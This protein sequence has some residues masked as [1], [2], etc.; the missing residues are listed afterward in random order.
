MTLTGLP[1]LYHHFPN[2]SAQQ[3]DRFA[4]LQGLYAEW[5]EKINVISRKDIENL[6][7][8]HVLHSLAI[9]KVV[10]FNP[11]AE[12]LDVGTGG[13][14]PGIPLAIL[15]PDTLFY[16][17]DSIGK[18]IVVVQAVKDA[19]GLDNVFAENIRSERFDGHV[20]FAVTRAVAP[21]ADL[22]QWT[23]GKI[24]KKS[25]HTIANGLL[26]LKGGDLKEELQPFAKRAKVFPLSKYYDDPF[27]AEKSV[28]YMAL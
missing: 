18:K 9:A 19:L 3:K 22:V 28:I 7:D 8:R 12:V 26:A 15:F 20:D 5:N 10:Q 21:M 13:G 1:L 11:G 27:Y 24:R 17:T 6:Y 14:F 25:N 16:C 23:K 4:Q 2:L